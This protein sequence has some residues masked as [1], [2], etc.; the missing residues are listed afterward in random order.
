MATMPLKEGLRGSK[1]EKLRRQLIKF[2]YWYYVK[3]D[4][5]VDD[6]TYDT[7]FKELECLEKVKDCLFHPTPYSPTQQ[8]WG[9]CESQYPNWARVRDC[10]ILYDD[11][12]PKRPILKGKTE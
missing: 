6:R 3:A 8:I 2:C 1:I 7:L 5:L 12:I 11:E 9:D 10:C 4:P